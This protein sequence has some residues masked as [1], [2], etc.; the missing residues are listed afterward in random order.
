MN[1]IQL[2]CFVAV[3]EF[4]NFTKAAEALKIT[5]PAVSHQ[6]HSLEDELGTKL[7]VRNKRK[8]HL[9]KAG[10]QF[11][12][13]ATTILGIEVSVK[14]RLN[15]SE[16]V[17]RLA[18]AVGCHNQLELHLLPPILRALREA[19][20]SLRP[21][22]RLVPSE[23]MENLLEDGSI[24]VMFSMRDAAGVSAIGTCREL[25][26]CPI[27]CVCPP[28]HPL[29]G[30]ESLT[31]AQLTGNLVLCEPRSAP[32]ALFKVQSHAAQLRPSSQNFFCGGYESVI[33]LVRAGVGF[34]L[35]PDVP[36]AREHGLSYIPVTGLD[37]ISLGV[38]YKS[39]R[40]NPVLRRFVELAQAV[41]ED[42]PVT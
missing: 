32:D 9:T 30:Y 36:V 38:L 25:R 37:P 27:A 1:S 16:E 8:V 17:S 4:L 22:I 5:Q 40:G 29:A 14:A 10:M 3:A 18:L 42:A 2:E 6:I 20:P 13:D 15:E 35:L 7:F 12:G 19:Y 24:Q 28:D 39:L 33:A 26:K 31:E 11:I 34:T 41:T 23:A 21:S